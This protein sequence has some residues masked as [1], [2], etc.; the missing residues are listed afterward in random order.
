MF[1]FRIERPVA[2]CKKTPSRHTPAG[3]RSAHCVLLTVV[4]LWGKS[5]VPGMIAHSL[6]DSLVAFLFFAKHL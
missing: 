4:A 1:C 2:L 6:E 5:L 3:A